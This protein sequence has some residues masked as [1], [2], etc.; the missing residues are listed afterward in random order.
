MVNLQ[1]TLDK[2]RA[3]RNWTLSAKNADKYAKTGKA[4]YLRRGIDQ[5]DK[6]EDLDMLA[7]HPYVSRKDAKKAV[8]ERR[9]KIDDERFKDYLLNGVNKK[10]Y[11]D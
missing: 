2:I 3:D 1:K 8:K 7:T 5:A 9:E 6:A 11:E 10:Y 4:K